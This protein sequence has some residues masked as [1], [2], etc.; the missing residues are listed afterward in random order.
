MNNL[1]LIEKIATSNIAWQ[2]SEFIAFLADSNESYYGYMSLSLEHDKI[3]F[4]ESYIELI[5]NDFVSFQITKKLLYILYKNSKDQERLKMR[6]GYNILNSMNFECVCDREYTTIELLETVL[7]KR[8]KLSTALIAVWP[9]L[10]P[11]EKMHWTGVFLKDNSLFMKSFLEINRVKDFSYY[12]ALNFNSINFWDISYIVQKLIEYGY[13]ADS[14]IAEIV[15]TKAHKAAKE[16]VQGGYPITQFIDKLDCGEAA[17]LLIDC[18]KQLSKELIQK[19]F[20]KLDYNYRYFL[21]RHIE[22]GVLN[23]QQV[24]N[25]AKYC[26]RRG[27]LL[28]RLCDYSTDEFIGKEI[29]NWKDNITFKKLLMQNVLRNRI[30]EL[31]TAICNSQKFSYSEQLQLAAEF[32]VPNRS[33]A[34]ANLVRLSGRTDCNNKW[35]GFPDYYELPDYIIRLLVSTKGVSTPDEAMVILREAYCKLTRRERCLLV[36]IAKKDKANAETMLRHSGNGDRSYD[37]TERGRERLL[38]FIY[39]NKITA[40]CAAEAIKFNVSLRKFTNDDLV[41]IIATSENAIKDV[42]F[43]SRKLLTE[44]QQIVLFRALS[45]KA[46]YNFVKDTKA[47][48]LT[49]CYGEEVGGVIAAIINDNL[50]DATT[51]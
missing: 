40:N 43:Y 21:L 46:L 7:T 42:L 48:Y 30:S 22:A 5:K 47:R 28:L 13:M 16:L 4:S 18:G 17:F 10:S 20:E 15:L 32:C 8:G 45:P 33:E 19:L 14:T 9:V 35:Y 31:K 27:A 25:L 34:R 37:L 44:Q 26:D 6:L 49:A 36:N 11:A 50:E 2:D 1:H 51:R 39:D 12:A 23:E 24:L 38:Y 41:K 29:L 3:Q